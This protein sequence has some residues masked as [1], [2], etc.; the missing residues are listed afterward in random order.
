MLI[1]RTRD[2]I[3]APY[4]PYCGVFLSLGSGF[5]FGLAFGAW[6]IFGGGL[7]LPAAP[8]GGF[9]RSFGVSA[10]SLAWSCGGLLMFGATALLV[11]GLGFTSR[12]TVSLAFGVSSRSVGLLP[13]L[14][15]GVW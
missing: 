1:G 10:G 8:S 6:A 5:A 3:S 11:G 15:G 12:F 9:S 2:R 4:S 13:G 7:A 14:A